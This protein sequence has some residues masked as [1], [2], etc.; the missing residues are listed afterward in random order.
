MS[1]KQRTYLN[2]WL[3]LNKE[4]ELEALQTRRHVRPEARV[5]TAAADMMGYPIDSE[6]D[7][8]GEKRS[9]KNGMRQGE[10]RGWWMH[11][12]LLLVEELEVEGG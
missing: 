11:T 6:G 2:I 1:C 8:K 12:V 9:T 10:S 7:S 5:S 3:V 4:L